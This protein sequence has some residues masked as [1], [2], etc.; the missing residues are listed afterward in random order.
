MKNLTFASLAVCSIV[1]SFG[2]SS[3]AVAE[4]PAVTHVPAM[5]TITASQQCSQAEARNFL[6]QFI[7][8]VKTD[9]K[10][11]AA[12]MFLYPKMFL[13]NGETSRYISSADELLQYYDKIFTEDFK[14]HLSKIDTDKLTCENDNISADS[15]RI[16]L[17]RHNGTLYISSV[18]TAADRSTG[19][20][21][22]E[23]NSRD[24]IDTAAFSGNTINYT[25]P[26]IQNSMLEQAN[27][28]FSRNLARS[29]YAYMPYSADEYGKVKDGYLKEQYT[30]AELNDIA[31]IADF[32]HTKKNKEALAKQEYSNRYDMLADYKVKLNDHRYLSILQSIYTYSGGAHGTTIR[33]SLTLD[34][35]TG[36]PVVLSDLFDSEAYLYTLN[37]YASQQNKDIYLY[38]P[39]KITGQESFYLTDNE[40]V[41]YYQQYEVAPYAAGFVEYHFPYTVLQSVLK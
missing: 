7:R 29:M 23:G 41:I 30:A 38:E 33:Y 34:K 31:Q 14:E 17:T 2:I 36:A 5:V 25:L 39:V 3:Y 16:W 22:Y 27:A 9:D 6:R 19:L 37:D 15:E 8:A 18:F 40:L 21:Y 1:L 13:N 26:F 20:V 35:K 28:Y 32:Y 12:K 24:Y 4:T 11:A 10:K